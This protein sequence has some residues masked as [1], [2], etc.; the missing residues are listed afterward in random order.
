[1]LEEKLLRIEEKL[2]GKKLLVRGLPA[3]KQSIA[4]NE[5]LTVYNHL[6]GDDLALAISTSE[7]VICRAGYTSVMELVTMRQKAILVPTPGQTEQEYLAKHL[8]ESGWFSSVAQDDDD[9]Y[10]MDALLRAKENNLLLPPQL[11]ESTL[12]DFI[13]QFIQRLNKKQ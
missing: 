2:P 9:V 6:Q 8:R 7:I 12:A 4:G 3:V 1:M 10:F 11:E 5:G 13:H